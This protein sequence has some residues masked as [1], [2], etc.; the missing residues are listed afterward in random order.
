M[1]Q[2]IDSDW[3]AMDAPRVRT[4]VNGTRY[5]DI[6]LS[7]V[8]YGHRIAVDLTRNH[9]IVHTWLLPPS[10]HHRLSRSGVEIYFTIRSLLASR[11]IL[12][13]KFSL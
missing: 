3:A 11:A 13:R 12:F 9:T 8:D 2:I 7:W 6:I 4:L 10:A 5:D 1:A